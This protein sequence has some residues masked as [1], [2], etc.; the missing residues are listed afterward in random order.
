MRRSAM[1]HENI[2]VDGILSDYDGLVECLLLLPS[3]DHCNPQM[4]EACQKC[5][6]KAQ[7]HG[8]SSNGW[9]AYRTWM[10]QVFPDEFEKEITPDNIK[11]S[12]QRF[13]SFMQEKIPLFDRTTGKFQGYY[14]RKTKRI[15]DSP[16]DVVDL[17]PEARR[18]LET[19]D[20]IATWV[21]KNC[22]FASKKCL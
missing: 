8:F 13:M 14:N 9:N 18:W 6:E 19:D 7:Q 15:Q 10:K 22:K 12:Y 5:K 4:E 3:L 2:N 11:S 1:P 20:W 17:D 16:I 21:H